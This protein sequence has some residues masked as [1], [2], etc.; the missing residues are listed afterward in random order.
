MFVARP[1][2]VSIAI[3]AISSAKPTFD[4]LFIRDYQL[5]LGN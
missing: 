4:A 3:K 5:S 2:T 1:K